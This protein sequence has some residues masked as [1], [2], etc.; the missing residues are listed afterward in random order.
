MKNRV[1][2]KYLKLTRNFLSQKIIDELF[3]VTN[4]MCKQCYRYDTEDNDTSK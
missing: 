4:S 1:Q 2:E 3:P